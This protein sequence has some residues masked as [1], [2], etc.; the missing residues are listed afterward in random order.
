MKT[1]CKFFI[2]ARKSS[3]SEDR[4]VQSKEDQIRIMRAKAKSMGI[5]VVKEF[6]ESM[7]AKDTGRSWFNDMIKRINAWEAQWI[8][9]WKIDRLTRNPVDTWTLQYMLQKWEI[10]VIVTNDR[11]YYQEDSWLIFSV[12]SW[13]ATQYIIDLRKNVNRGLNTKYEKWIRPTKTPLW[14]KNDKNNFWI[15][16]EDP[17]KFE[18]VKKMWELMLSWNYLV[19]Q[20]IEIANNDWGLRTRIMKNSWWCPVSRA[21]VYRIFNNIFYTWHFYRNWELKKWIHTPMITLAEFDKVQFILGKK[22]NHRP[23][24]YEFSYTWLIKCWECWAMITA[25]YKQKFIISQQKVKT[26]IYYHCTG[27]KVKTQCNQKTILIE[28]LEAQILDILDSIEIEPS[29]K[30]R[31]LWVVKDNYESSIKETLMMYEKINTTINREEI[32]LKKLTDLL[33]EEI[34]TNDDYKIKKSSLLETIER[35]KEQRDKIDTRW[36]DVL[37]QTEHVFNFLVNVKDNFLNWSLQVKREIFSSLGKNFIL[38]DWILSLELHPWFNII[39]KWLNNN[40]PEK[41]RFEP[42]KNSTNFS[43]VNAISNHSIKWSGTWDSNS[44]PHAPKACAL[45][46][47]ASSRM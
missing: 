42:T 1:N 4:Q 28:L 41:D 33:L 40:W 45:A 47:C 31:A 2:Y 11:E 38:K 8:L 43:K 9:C 29:F 26:Y 44:Q 16:V 39:W 18:I 34:I 32:K 30:E 46:N 5:K 3:E 36:K 17:E 21:S 37:E 13:M 24:N 10:E 22:W 23:Q 6:S 19:P 7:S 20:V 25:E 35:L 27:R 15:A 14:Y 12:E